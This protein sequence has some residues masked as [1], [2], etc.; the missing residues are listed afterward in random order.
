MESVS[1]PQAHGPA[2]K[3][4]RHGRARSVYCATISGRCRKSKSKPHKIWSTT[5]DLINGCPN[6]LRSLRSY[7]QRSRRADRR[8]REACIGAPTVSEQTDFY[9]VRIINTVSFQIL[10]FH[11][12][13]NPF[14]DSFCMSA[15]V[16]YLVRESERCVVFY[17]HPIS[18]QIRLWLL[19]RSAEKLVH[20]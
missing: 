7:A 8:E 11:C 9:V 5:L 6:L 4:E 16:R 10:L 20:G 14:N 19:S 1:D 18:Y 15:T 3:A 2:G 12:S 13:Q 17:G